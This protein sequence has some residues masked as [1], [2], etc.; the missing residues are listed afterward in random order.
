MLRSY[1]LLS[2][3]LI[4]RERVELLYSRASG[5]GG[6]NI[7]AS[8]SKVQLRFEI[9]QA[10]W[11]PDSVRAQLAKHYG[12]VLVIASQESRSCQVNEKN[13]FSK[14]TALLQ[15]TSDFLSQPK[16]QFA[17]F[18]AWLTA[19]RTDKQITRYKSIREQGKRRDATL[20]R[21]T[22]VYYD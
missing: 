7:A 22:Q 13:C 6:Q 5:P 21:N 16:S 3:I 10:D 1:R 19:V 8:N 17:S 15:Q 9:A 2:N 4:P 11:I 12:R 18:D 14:L 20:R